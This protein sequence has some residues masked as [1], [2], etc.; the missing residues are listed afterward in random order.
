M[1]ESGIL[2]PLLGEQNSFFLPFSP[3]SVTKHDEH[4]L[5]G[6]LEEQLTQTQC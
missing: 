4:N 2:P 6:N 1:D 5:T 3:I